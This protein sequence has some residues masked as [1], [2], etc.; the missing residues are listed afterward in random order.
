MEKE[1]FIERFWKV[2]ESGSTVR[3]E[4]IAGITT[5]LTMAYIVFVNPAIISAPANV[6]AAYFFGA[7]PQTVQSALFVTTCLCACMGTM[8]MA[9]LAKVPFAQAPGMGLNAFFAYT[10]MLGMGKTYQEALAIVLI[11]GLL[12]IV[13]TITGLREA[14][15]RGIPANIRVAISGGIGLFIAYSGLKNAGLIQ[16]TLDPGTYQILNPA[17]ELGQSTVVASA[18]AIPGL[19]DFSTWT[20]QTAGA[21]LSLIGLVIIAALHAYKCKGYIFLGIVITT[22]IGIPMGVTMLPQS[23]NFGQIGT[24]FQDWAQVSLFNLDF[25]SLIGDGGL[26]SGILNIVMAVI[27]FSMVDMFDTLG[28]VIGTAQQANMLDEN[29]EFPALKRTLMADS[30]ATAVIAF[31]MVDMFDTLGT[32]IGTAQQANMLDENGEFPAL[33]RTLMADSIATTAGSLMGSSTVTTYVESSAGVSEGGRTGLTAFVTAVLFLLALVLSPI[34]G[35]IPSA[36]TAPALIF[37]GVLMISAVKNIDFSDITE[38]VP[39]FVTLLF[40]PLTFSIADG[41]AFGLITYVVIKALSRKFEDLQMITV[42]LSILFVLRFLL[43]Q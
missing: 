43:M 24:Q 31:S 21:V 4:I 12:F 6:D 10:I 8:L 42:I 40:M 14:I 27:A 15:V 29:G 23:L 2:R 28:T 18:A 7:D 37:V 26:F 22:V 36:A 30:I 13:L 17:A 1:N 32:V 20:P 11:S 9:F 16:F 19:I 33:K 25:A 38:A 35:I 39:A 34:L 5:F 41:I 3:T